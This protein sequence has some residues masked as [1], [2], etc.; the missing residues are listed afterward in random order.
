MLTRYLALKRFIFHWSI[1]IIPPTSKERIVKKWIFD[2]HEY[3]LSCFFRVVFCHVVKYSCLWLNIWF[4]CQS[5]SVS[6]DFWVCKAQNFRL[7]QYFAN[8]KFF[9]FKTVAQSSYDIWLFLH[10]PCVCDLNLWLKCSIYD[11]PRFICEWKY[12]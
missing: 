8:S 12:Y 6:N 2:V 11:F 4:S 10:F 5:T 1:E 9:L 3:L 7:K